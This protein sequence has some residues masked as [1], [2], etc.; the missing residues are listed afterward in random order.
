VQPTFDA[1]VSRI[2]GR[3]NSRALT[4]SL[5][6]AAPAR[7]APGASAELA[8]EAAQFWRRAAETDVGAAYALIAE[9]HPGAAPEVGATSFAR[10]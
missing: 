10:P 3:L 2:D 4:A 7:A 6:Y 9:N 5:G 8:A 1:V